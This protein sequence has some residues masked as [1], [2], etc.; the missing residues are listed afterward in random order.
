MN[1]R[2]K[3]FSK[4][5]QKAF[6]FLQTAL[7]VKSSENVPMETISNSLDLSCDTEVESST[8]LIHVTEA[9]SSRQIVVDISAA[10]IDTVFTG[11]ISDQPK[12][13]DRVLKKSLRVVYIP[14]STTSQMTLVE[15]Q[16]IGSDCLEML[17]EMRALLNV[18]N[19][20]M[21]TPFKAPSISDT[22]C[23]GHEIRSTAIAVTQESKGRESS[24]TGPVD[25]HSDSLKLPDTNEIIEECVQKSNEPALEYWRQKKG[26]RLFMPADS[27]HYPQNEL[28]SWLLGSPCYGNAFFAFVEPTE[29]KD[30]TTDTLMQLIASFTPLGLLLSSTT[31]NP[32]L[33]MPIDYVPENFQKLGLRSPNAVLSEILSKRVGSGAG[34]KVTHS[35]VVIEPGS[36]D[37]ELGEGGAIPV[38]SIHTFSATASLDSSVY[39][40]DGIQRTYT[41]SLRQ[42]KSEA[43]QAVNLQIL[44]SYQSRCDEFMDRI[45]ILF[46]DEKDPTKFY[47][48]HPGIGKVSVQDSFCSSMLLKCHIKYTGNMKRLLTTEYFCDIDCLVGVGNLNG[49]LERA[50]LRDDIDSTTLPVIVQ[51]VNLPLWHLTKLLSSTA[52]PSTMISSMDEI[53]DHALRN[54]ITFEL[55]TTIVS[56]AEKKQHDPL[57]DVKDAAS[58]RLFTK[59]LSRQRHDGK[60][61][62]LLSNHLLQYKSHNL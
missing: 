49:S 46:F 55:T 54:Q 4:D 41:S 57:R 52:I 28:S 14:A 39:G 61:F 31:I 13:R 48:I 6:S 35:S 32:V 33:H 43:T 44:S 26:P 2:D 38:K 29:M 16:I 30:S 24:S 50:I 1:K 9:P 18:E 21:S 15:T 12:I 37:C 19:I 47:L 3:V 22:T 42:S 7:A 23:S 62:A 8:P 36:H 11:H 60:H 58:V 10:A 51:E 53:L 56:R 5:P 27:A 25:T 20:T 34:L 45:H 17:E 59:P 40:F